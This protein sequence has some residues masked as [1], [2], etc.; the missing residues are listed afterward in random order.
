MLAGDCA[1][2]IVMMASKCFNLCYAYN[3]LS[4]TFTEMKIFIY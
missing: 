4:W 3:V 1:I 2:M